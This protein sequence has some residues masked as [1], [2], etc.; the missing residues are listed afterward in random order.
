[1]NILPSNSPPLTEEQISEIATN[2]SKMNDFDCRCL[3]AFMMG[4]LH[5]ANNIEA[6]RQAFFKQILANQEVKI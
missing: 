5:H 2:P 1:M 6:T 4:Y 3:V